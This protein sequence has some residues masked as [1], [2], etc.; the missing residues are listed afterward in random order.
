METLR[1]VV[2]Q[3]QRRSTAIPNSK[4]PPWLA[5]E[6]YRYYGFFALGACGCLLFT[7]V[8][9]Y[10]LKFLLRYQGV[11]KVTLNY[12]TCPVKYIFL[13]RYTVGRLRPHYLT[14]CKP[15][16]GADG[17]CKDEWDYNRWPRELQM[18]S[19]FHC[20]FQVC[21]GGGARSLH[22]SAQRRDNAKSTS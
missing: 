13:D 9:K 21:C 20:C 5:V 14:L 7:E 11:V 12:L 16:Y 10:Y 19:K 4:Y 3:G 6:L 1:S 8:A 15:D 17:L 22:R 2:L 18:M